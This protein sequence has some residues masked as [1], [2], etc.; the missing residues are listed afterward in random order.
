MVPLRIRFGKRFSP[1]ENGKANGA[2]SSGPTTRAASEGKSNGRSR[3][4]P[5][6]PKVL[7]ATAGPCVVG[8]RQATQA[9][10]RDIK[11]RR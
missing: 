7:T 8:K 2:D 3:L 1:A 10:L 9:Q 4:A 11:K 6:A 5:L